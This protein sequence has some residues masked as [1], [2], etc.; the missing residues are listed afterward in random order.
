MQ[1]HQV[2]S[3]IEQAKLAGAGGGSDAACGDL[4]H[5]LARLAHA[6][7]ELLREN[8]D[9]SGRLMRRGIAATNSGRSVPGSGQRNDSYP[10][11]YAR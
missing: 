8:E 5:L 9:L 11:F 2:H 4:R 6:A 10:A 3:L 1:R 7:E